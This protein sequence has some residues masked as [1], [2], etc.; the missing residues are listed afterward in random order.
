MTHL[1]FTVVGNDD[2][3]KEGQENHVTNENKH[4]YI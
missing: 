3:H 1:I 2:T 4:M